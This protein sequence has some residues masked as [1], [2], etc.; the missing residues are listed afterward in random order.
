MIHVTIKRKNRQTEN[1]QSQSN[2]TSY[3]LTVK[4]LTRFVCSEIHVTYLSNGPRHFIK[5][6]LGWLFV[7][8][9]EK[10]K[11]TSI[12]TFAFKQSN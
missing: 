12:P 5:Y 2:E 9:V 4:Q 7:S 11:S 10:L 1:Q 8:Y 3:K 6:R